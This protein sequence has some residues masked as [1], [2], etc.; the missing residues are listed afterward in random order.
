MIHIIT[1]V[2]SEDDIV[3]ADSCLTHVTTDCPYHKQIPRLRAVL[4]RGFRIACDDTRRC[5]TFG[6][7]YEINPGW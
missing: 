1:F 5:L 2:T 3:A 4:S 6:N 7:I